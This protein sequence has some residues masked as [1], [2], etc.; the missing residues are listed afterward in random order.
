LASSVTS[1]YWGVAGMESTMHGFSWLLLSVVGFVSFVCGLM[2]SVTSLRRRHQAL[3]LY[4]MFV[5]ML[6]NVGVVKYSLDAYQLVMP[7]I[8]VTLSFAISVINELLIGNS[9]EQFPP[10]TSST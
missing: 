9:D 3:V 6:A 4:V 10:E 8:M 1:L 7:W 5:S 2:G